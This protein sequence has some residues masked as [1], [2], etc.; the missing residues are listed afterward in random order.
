MSYH[1]NNLLTKQNKILS[2]IKNYKR[3]DN[4]KLIYIVNA[5]S[6]FSFL[7]INIIIINIINIYLLFPPS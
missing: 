5:F 3:C 7:L 6:L 2:L 4:I 1:K